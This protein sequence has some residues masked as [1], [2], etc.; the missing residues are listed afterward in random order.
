MSTVQQETSETAGRL[1]VKWAWGVE[2]HFEN[3][4]PGAYWELRENEPHAK[5]LTQVK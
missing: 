2:Q 4:E 5:R 3:L 1:T